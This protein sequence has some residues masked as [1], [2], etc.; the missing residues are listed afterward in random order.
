M[1]SGAPIILGGSSAQQRR[2]EGVQ[3]R[4]SDKMATDDGM[5]GEIFVPEIDK[6]LDAENSLNPANYNKDQHRLHHGIIQNIMTDSG[7]FKESSI[8][9]IGSLAPQQLN[10]QD[11]ILGDSYSPRMVQDNQIGFRPRSPLSSEA[12]N[13][14]LA[15]ALEGLNQCGNS[16]INDA[17]EGLGADSSCFDSHSVIKANRRIK[18]DR[19]KAEQLNK[20]M[21]ETEWLRESGLL[22]NGDSSNEVSAND[23]QK[24]LYDGQNIELKNDHV[25]S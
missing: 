7:A 11:H 20:Q 8:R 14:E 5:M 4:R 24:Q 16:A 15:Q 2:K 25:P 6:E 3:D 22:G 9:Q 1:T 17:S 18:Q 13:M 19:K 12:E 23:L 21:Q 10:M